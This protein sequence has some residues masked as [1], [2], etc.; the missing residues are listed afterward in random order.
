MTQAF[1]QKY[2]LAHKTNNLKKQI[3]NFTQNDSENFYQVWERFKTFLSSCPH[4]GFESWRAVSY[5]YDGILS[6][7]RQFFE[8]MCKRAFLQKEHEEATDFLDDI[9]KKS[10]NWNGSSAL[11]ST[12]RNLPAGIY[13]LKEEDS[14]KAHLET[15]RGF[16][17]QRC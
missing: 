8:S 9:S 4:H 15:L 14:L 1:F 11:D 17:D 16:K 5:F 13:Q 6:R 12:N 2:F 3:Q 7:D 10:L